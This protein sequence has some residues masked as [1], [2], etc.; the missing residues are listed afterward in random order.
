MSGN[1]WK[2]M[3]VAVTAVAGLLAAKGV[4]TAWKFI[5]GKPA[6]ADP[7]QPDDSTWTEALI[8]AAVA[9]VAVSVVRVVAERKAAEYY[10]NSTGHLP[11][12]MRPEEETA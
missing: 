4:E 8:F 6:P 2:V 3:S 11:P 9:G 5:S 10:R 12:P 1:A 7:A